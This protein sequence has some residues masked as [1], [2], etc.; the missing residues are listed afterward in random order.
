MVKARILSFVLLLG[1]S[2]SALDVLCQSK[3]AS[4]PK[5]EFAKEPFSSNVEKLPAGFKG[6]SLIG[7]FETLR[8]RTISA[9]RGE[10][11][12][13][14]SYNSR[15]EKMN[16]RPLLGMVTQTSRLAFSFEPNED[17][18][19]TRYYPDQ[20]VLSIMLSWNSRTFDLG[21]SYYS[22]VT[23]SRSYVARNAFNVAV[24]VLETNKEEYLLTT[25][26]P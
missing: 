15:I 17:Q 7:V 9:Q 26:L 11:E 21:L 13:S 25:Y 14:S 20:S 12:S 10:F 23:K 22:E 4:R 3:K 24:I 8:I 5:S 16:A 1:L 6:N 2:G 18:F 19:T